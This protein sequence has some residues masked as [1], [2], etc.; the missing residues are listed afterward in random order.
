MK[1]ISRN[2]L[3]PTLAIF[4]I[5]FILRFFLMS[6]I[7]NFCFH[8]FS[9]DSLEKILLSHLFIVLEACILFIFYKYLFFTKNIE[10]FK[11]N[12][13]KNSIKTGIFVGLFIFLTSVPVGLY[14]GMKI[15]PHFSL[16]NSVG[17]VFSNGAEEI[18]YRGI[19]FTALYSVFKSNW[20]SITASGIMFGIAHW[21]LPYLLQSY[22]AL[23][24]IIL[25]W[26]YVKSKSLFI[27]FIAHMI[28]D[29]LADSLLQ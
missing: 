5:W 3:I 16:L 1:K 6:K 8:N 20:I 18:I 10:G 24:G 19:I 29:L 2:T 4:A 11:F 28:A 9:F 22:I 14:F 23:T 27:P 7:K 13:S 21:D 12:H 15:N 26:T 25:A 17:N